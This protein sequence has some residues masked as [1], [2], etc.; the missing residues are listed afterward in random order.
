MNVDRFLLTVNV[1]RQISQE[2]CFCQYFKS[3]P[4]ANLMEQCYYRNVARLL[5]FKGELR[6]RKYQ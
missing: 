2:C 1:L 4:S 6:E 5:V 3:F